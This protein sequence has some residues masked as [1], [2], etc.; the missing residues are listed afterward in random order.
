MRSAV[1]EIDDGEFVPR[2][3]SGTQLEPKY[4]AALIWEIRTGV[5]ALGFDEFFN[6]GKTQL[7]A[8]CPGD[9]AR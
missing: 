4:A 5:T 7:G 6:E 1:S 3:R 2:F 9:G 8:F